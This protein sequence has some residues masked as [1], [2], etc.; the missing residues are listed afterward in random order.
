[1]EP[2]APVSGQGL[3]RLERILDPQTHW[4]FEPGHLGVR[5]RFP[6]IQNLAA[7]RRIVMVLLRQG[8]AG[9]PGK[10]GGYAPALGPSGA[11]QFHEQRARYRQPR[12]DHHIGDDLGAPAR[13]IA[14]EGLN[15][16]T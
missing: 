9:P 12:V 3:H 10:G 8:R 6:Q 13:L 7:Q 14:G 4:R 16:M 1:M 15:H 5:D 2:A 11:G